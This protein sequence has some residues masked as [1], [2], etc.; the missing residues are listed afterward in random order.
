MHR[1]TTIDPMPYPNTPNLDQ[2][3]PIGT[4][5]IAGY[6]DA[7]NSKTPTPGGGAVA[8]TTGATAAA[9]AGM[10]VHYTL[11]KKKYAEYESQNTDRLNQLTNAQSRFLE[12]ADADAA[13]YGALN[14]L[15]SLPETDPVRQAGWD[16]A[17]TGAISP[18]T[19]MLD[20]CS[21]LIKIVDELTGTTNRQLRSDLAVSAITFRAAAHSAACN[22]RINIPL[23]NE[24]DRDPA[25]QSMNESLRQIDALA[26]TIMDACR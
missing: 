25:T 9:I 5:T 21:S 4:Q 3:P 22:I 2:D 17:V 8:G 24:H 23:L 10:V 12:L 26:E 6:L 1:V 13:G 16:N 14:S 19:E 15:W 18:P 11:G 7:I 20:L